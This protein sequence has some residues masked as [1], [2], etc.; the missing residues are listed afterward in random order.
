MLPYL[1]SAFII[2]TGAFW[3]STWILISILFCW[4]QRARALLRGFIYVNWCRS[5]LFG[6]R[7]HVHVDGSVGEEPCLL[8]SN[9]MSSVD[10]PLLGSQANAVFVAKKEIGSWPVIGWAVTGIGTIYIDRKN[11]HQVA[12]I[13]Q[14]TREAFAKGYW[15][16][17][18][19]EGG[20]TPAD[21]IYPLKSP[22]LEPFV[23]DDIP[24][25]Y[26]T[27]RYETGPGDLPVDE[28]VAWWGVGM[29]EHLTRLF[30][31]RRIDGYLT[32][33]EYTGPRED[34]KALARG[35]M[36]VMSADFQPA[37]TS[38]DIGKDE[39]STAVE[40]A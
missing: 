8:V 29:W 38:D 36:E 4:S 10:I 6:C 34:R 5:I 22:L 39:R 3:L 32:I 19:P 27:I 40:L 17:I 14:K 25:R 37:R 15:I 21:K 31:C 1:K 28:A 33:R 18:F 24:I 12:E 23:S 11:R 26:A 20:I 7:A 2:V 16:T 30:S 35:L 9:H 13:N